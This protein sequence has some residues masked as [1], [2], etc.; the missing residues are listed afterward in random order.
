MLMQNTRRTQA[1]LIRMFVYRIYILLKQTG[2]PVSIVATAI[3]CIMVR[4]CFSHDKMRR[5]VMVVMRNCMYRQQKQVRYKN[6]YY[7]GVFCHC[8]YMEYPA[9]I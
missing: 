8:F 5:P 2:L 9:K 6:E 3:V 1:M 7:A 4:V